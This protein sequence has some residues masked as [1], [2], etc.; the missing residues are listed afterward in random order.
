MQPE[1]LVTFK[2]VRVTQKKG[3]SIILIVYIKGM[4]FNK[5]WDKIFLINNPTFKSKVSNQYYSF[6]DSTAV[7][8]YAAFKGAHP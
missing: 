8:T 1:Y 5:W 6:D 4:S 7:Y 2:A 3:I